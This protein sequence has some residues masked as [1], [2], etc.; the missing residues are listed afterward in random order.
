MKA[1]VIN[2][3]IAVRQEKINFTKNL[4]PATLE[5]IF[6]DIKTS[7]KLEDLVR[8]LRALDDEEEQR[9]FKQQH[10]PYF[11]LGTF[12]D[13]H[14]LNN[15]LISTSFFIYDYDYLDEKLEQMKNDLKH[16]ENVLA[17]FV[18]PRG[19][20][21]KVIY[22]L[23]QPITDYQQYSKL[24]KY[25]ANIYKIDLG[26]DPDKT[27]DASR[28]C[29]FSYDPDMYV[30]ESATPLETN[31]KFD[32]ELSAKRKDST[33]K[34]TSATPGD[35][36]HTA[37]QLIGKYIAHGFDKDF[38][39]E[40]LRLWNNQNNP[41]LPDDKLVYTVNDMYER[42][43]DKSKYLAVKFSEKNN[44]YFKTVKNGKDFIQTMVTSFRITPKELLV[45]DNS[46]C[47]KCD[48]ESSQGNKYENI[49][50]ENTDWHTKQK[51]LKALGHQDC[52]F[53]GSENDLQAL[54]QY[55]Q[56]SIPIR[57][58]GTKVIGL[59]G[60]TWVAEGVN[61]TSKGKEEHLT[62]VPYDKGSDAFYHKI[63]YS[64]LKIHEEQ[65][66]LGTLYDNVLD[67]N[68]REKILA[69]LG[70][71][72]VTP[73]KPKVEKELGGFPLLFQHG[74]HGSGKTTLS[75]LFARLFGYADPTPNS[76]TL[77]SFPM[78]KLLSSTN[79]V[80]Q[81]YDEFKVADM[82]END[83]DNILRYMRKCYA[84]EIESKGRADQTIE[85]YKLSAPIAVMGEWN[86]NQPAIMERVVLVRFNDII[87]KD[88]N[89]RRAFRV[90]NELPLEGFM[91][92]YIQFC[93]AKDI[94]EILRA[95]TEF[96]EMHFSNTTIA[97]RVLKNLAVMITGLELFREYAHVNKLV[98]PQ[99]KYEELLDDQ[100]EE[101]TGSKKGTV[102]SAVDQLIEE[103]SIMADKNEI[104]EQDYRTVTISTGRKVLAINFK[105]IF[106]DFK[107][108]AKKTSYEGDLLD[109]LSYGKMFDDCEYIIEKNRKVKWDAKNTKR[110]LC[111]DIELVKEYG[112]SIDGFKIGS[113]EFQLVPDEVE[114]E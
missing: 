90:V 11:I 73:V 66:M 86:I 19:N 105:K 51:F 28:A 114:P 59:H 12:R 93:L 81:W 40:N 64:E 88:E 57:K 10:F 72:F 16:D 55:T 29:F 99:I 38:S 98:V 46:D 77:K 21:L 104:S 15:N 53:L 69:Y 61:I 22:K 33:V 107:A 58:K 94:S 70:W 102:R 92:R 1:K 111:I 9:K 31:V 71:L 76:V 6:N 101:L 34:I 3:Y 56:M 108:Y 25:Y 4:I 23:D 85:N 100:L 97:P 32:F 112:V 24:Y 84:G 49:L 82:K 62:L 7:K 75:K 35:R 68:K 52:V 89:M 42:Y 109:E 20:G 41:P 60:E 44:S 36:T 74:S 80:P 8:Q 14:R 91:P 30:N 45:M 78:L 13:N 18:S 67:V 106:R 96:C 87:K 50:I 113:N 63:K 83:V 43:E 26:A 37:T 39:L 110:C 65:C 95:A 54:C 27:S 17:F 5:N 2:D 79:A 47:L 48:I 103:L